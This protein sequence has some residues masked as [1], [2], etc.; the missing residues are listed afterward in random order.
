M[1]T[2]GKLHFFDVYRKKSAV[3]NEYFTGRLGHQAIVLFKNKNNPTGKEEKWSAFIQEPKPTSSS[4]S[5]SRVSKDKKVTKETKWIPE[6]A[7]DML[8]LF[9]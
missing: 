2:T 7:D 6:G 4:A 9:K 1:D 3:G 8:E 5:K